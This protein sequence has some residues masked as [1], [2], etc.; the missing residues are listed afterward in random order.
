MAHA[1][2]KHPHVR[3]EHGIEMAM[4]GGNHTAVILRMTLVKVGMP[5]DSFGFCLLWLLLSSKENS[6]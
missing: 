4:W 2:K 3:Q 1:G 6:I 5:E